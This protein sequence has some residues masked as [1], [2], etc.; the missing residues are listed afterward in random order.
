MSEW[1][2]RPLSQLADIRVSNVDKKS[3]PDEKS[4]LLCNYMDAY[5]N[6]YIRSDMSFMVATATA[7]EIAKFKVDC[8]DV[9][10]TKDS[11]TP[12]DIG[13]PS[14]VLEQIKDLVCGY[15]LALL[16]PRQDVVDPV[17]LCKQLGT[18]VSARYFGQRA[19]GSTRYGLSIGTLANIPILLPPLAKQQVISRVLVSIDTAI[20]KAEALIRKYQQIKAGLMHDLFTCGVLPNGKLRPPNT[21]VETPFGNMPSH[22]HLGSILELTDQ[23]RQPI[24]TGPFGADLGNADF[25]AEGVPVLRI[26]NVQQGRLD[27]ED[28]L[29]VSTRKAATLSRYRI[30]SGDLLFARQGATTGRNAL[31]DSRAEGC[32]I[33]YHI[34]RVALDHKRCSPLFV[35]AAFANEVIKRQIERDKGRGTREGINTAQ[36]TSLAFPIAPLEEQRLIDDILSCQSRFLRSAEAALHELRMRK[37]GLMQDLLTGKVPVRVDEQVTRAAIG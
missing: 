13:I 9:L 24:L 35:E 22:W 37:L 18:E 32:L 21:L 14:V 16:K 15:H 10:I 6:D 12:D 1:I 3:L 29:Y 28:L 26:G 11:E 5:A 23:Q 17:F 27:L 34:I 31:A 25:V 8:G 30:K 20:E 19:A 4:V 33:N 2:E 36:L 7:I